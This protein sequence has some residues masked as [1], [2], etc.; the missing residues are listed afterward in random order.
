MSPEIGG[1]NP[2]FVFGVA[3]TAAVVVIGWMFKANFARDFNWHEA[4]HSDS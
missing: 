3:A 1:W 4:D 2:A